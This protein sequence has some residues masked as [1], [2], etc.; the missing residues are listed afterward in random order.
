MSTP[1]P[2]SRLRTDVPVVSNPLDWGLAL[3]ESYLWGVA[4]VFGFDP[5][6]HVED[7]RQRD[8]LGGFLSSALGFM[9]PYM[10]MAK[11]SRL[12]KLARALGQVSKMSKGPFVSGGMTEVARMLPLEATRYAS[13]VLFAGKSPIDRAYDSLLM[14]GAEFGVGG[15]FGALRSMG[16]AKTAMERTLPPGTNLLGEDTLHLRGINQR[17]R[18]MTEEGIPRT[19]DAFVEALEYRASMERLVRMRTPLAPERVRGL[20]EPGRGAGAK[21]ESRGEGYLREM[22]ATGDVVANATELRPLFVPT[23]KYGGRKRPYEVNLLLGSTR[24]EVT[25]PLTALGLT[26]DAFGYMKNPR[27]LTTEMPKGVPA[28]FWIPLFK[29]EAVPQFQPASP[30]SRII[31]KNMMHLEDGIYVAREAEDGLFLMA[32]KLPGKADDLERWLYFQTDAPA[33]FAKKGAALTGNITAQTAWAREPGVRVEGVEVPI[34]DTLYRLAN[35]ESLVSLAQLAEAE[36]TRRGF[37]RK[38]A[39]MF[40][41]DEAADQAVVKQFSDFLETW[42]TPRAFQGVGRGRAVSPYILNLTKMSE[43]LVTARTSLAMD[44]IYSTDKAKS[45][46]WE[47]VLAKTQAAED[48]I[49]AHIGRLTER[50]LQ[51]FGKWRLL[52]ETIEVAEERLAAGAYSEGL[53]G[54]MRKADEVDRLVDAERAATQSITGVA[55]TASRASHLGIPHAWE[56]D[57]RIFV[58]KNSPT[59]P[60]ID[61]IGVKR[62]GPGQKYRQQLVAEAQAGGEELFY[63]KVVGA[64]EVD[65]LV[66]MT[67]AAKGDPAFRQSRNVQARILGETPL[68]ITAKPRTGMPG[69][70]TEFTQDSLRET[71]TNHYRR[72]FRYIAEQSLRS[73]VEPHMG[74]F[75]AYGDEHSVNMIMKNMNAAFGRPGPVSKIINRGFDKLLSPWLGKNSA[76]KISATVNKFMMHYLLGAWNMAYSSIAA[77]TFMQ[78]VLPELSLMVS[79]PA[80]RRAQLYNYLPIIQQTAK[81]KVIT[82]HVAQASVMKLMARGNAEMI[83]PDK[84]LRRALERG[85]QDHTFSHVEGQIRKVVASKERIAQHLASPGKYPEALVELSSFGL[86]A[87]ERWSRV[88]AFSIGWVMGRDFMGLSPKTQ[89]SSL[90]R[91]AKQ[92]ADSTMYRYAPADKAMAFGGPAGSIFGLFKQWSMHYIGN[93]MRYAN[94][95]FNHGNFK[96]LLWSVA[97]QTALGGVSISPVWAVGEAFN[98]FVSDEPLMET[99]YDTFELDDGNTLFSDAL[100]YGLPA[101]LGLSLS[102]QASAPFSDPARDASMIFSMVQLDRAS[103]LGRAIGGAGD[104]MTASGDWNPLTS[105]RVRDQFY[106]AL[107]PKTMYRAIAAFSTAGLKSLNTG[108]PIVEELGI[109]GKLSYMMGFTPNEIAKTYEVAGDLRDKKEERARLVSVFGRA[110]ADANIAGDQHEMTRLY[111]KAQLQGVEWS[112][113]IS[114]SITYM[115][116]LGV[117][118]MDRTFSPEEIE[119]RMNSLK[120]LR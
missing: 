106:R 73:A 112:S 108:Y 2:F 110:Y 38:A 19:D 36:P 115:H 89:W 5:P 28:P 14:L 64:N 20:V 109:A 34:Y 86:T 98:S 26:D 94:A 23:G 59:G 116:K 72:R 100:Y 22:E 63:S 53:M 55:V 31:G 1:T 102:A 113:V 57:W 11:I 93:M 43:D 35:E 82:G 66:F 13:G 117:G 3:G 48:S 33:Y 70:I 78:T 95:A 50:D 65:E 8:S 49:S 41:L 99:L 111:T 40:G 75:L 120:G 81:G 7:F 47:I 96:P 67:R 9:T 15:A 60:K 39:E 103:A 91:V 42:I 27:I 51:Q 62:P 6:E 16:K 29:G 61:T 56:G 101:T 4:D 46:M 76:T 10:G 30:L 80:W 87:P 118:I 77:L 24:E 79:M 104:Y 74:R 18:L 83:K 12:P 90:Y 71:L 85:L 107:A 25:A 105:P 32:M 52:E 97:G 69:F 58:H 37:L 114:S 119:S 68:P 92:F 54:F 88:N 45:A 21:V 44:G 84:Y 17:I